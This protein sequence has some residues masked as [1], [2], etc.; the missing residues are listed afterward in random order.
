MEMFYTDESI[1]EALHTLR[2]ERGGVLAD[3][4]VN[5]PVTGGI[6]NPGL[7]S[8]V[9]GCLFDADD[10]GLLVVLMDAWNVRKAWS[11]RYLK[12]SNMQE[13]DIKKGLFNFIVTIQ[14]SDDTRYKLQMMKRST[15][16]LPNQ[17][18]NVEYIVSLLETRM[19]NLRRKLF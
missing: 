19:L 5:H 13:I 17:Q 8:N 6:V 18:A 2:G 16:H 3:F 11:Y 9:T 12:Y 1:R 10:D 15:R 14:L 7:R 4:Y